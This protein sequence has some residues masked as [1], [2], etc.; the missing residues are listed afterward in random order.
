M[1]QR[2]LSQIHVLDEIKFISLSYHHLRY[3]DFFLN[4]KSRILHV[5]VISF[6]DFIWWFW[7]LWFTLDTVT[8]T[9]HPWLEEEDNVKFLTILT[10][11]LSWILHDKPLLRHTA[12][13]WIHNYRIWIVIFLGFL[14]YEIEKG[15]VYNTKQIL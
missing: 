8:L 12:V 4:V 5:H 7:S 1:S 13:R 2:Y 9:Y 10:F 15:V 6:S 3:F 11:S 14:G